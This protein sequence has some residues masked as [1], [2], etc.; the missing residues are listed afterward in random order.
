MKLGK[1]ATKTL[2]MLR[3]AFGEH[4]LSQNGIHILRPVECQLKMTNVQSHLAPAERQKILKTFENSSIKTI[5]EQSVSL[6]TLLGS[7]MEFARRY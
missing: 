2:K 7:L 1:S 4:S 5:A 6:Q 3:E